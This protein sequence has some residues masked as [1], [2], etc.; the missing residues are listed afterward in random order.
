MS[1]PLLSPDRHSD[2]HRHAAH[3]ASF[4][5]VI[6]LPDGRLLCAYRVSAAHVADQGYSRL[7][8]SESADQGRTW[9]APRALAGAGHC[10][11]MALLPDDSLM[12]LDDQANQVFHSFDAGKSF[13]V[14]ANEGDTRFSLPDRPLALAKGGLGTVGHTHRGRAAQPRCGQAP[15]E[16]LF[17]RSDNGGRSWHA[18]SVMHYD[19]AL[20]LCEASVTRLIDGRLLALC[21]ENSGVGEP[22][23]ALFSADDGET[24]S[25]P[26]PTH[27]P[28]HRP[29][30]G[31][32]HDGR[33]LVTY[34]DVGPNPGTSAFLGDLDTLLAGFAP[35][36]RWLA[37]NA[38][39]LA[40]GALRLDLAPSA[41]RWRLVLRPLTDPATATG[42]L[43]VRARVAQGED[44][45]LGI[46]FGGSHFRLHRQHLLLL[47]PG[48]DEPH[49]SWP[50]A[51]GEF[52][53]LELAYRRGVTRLR[54]NGRSLAEIPAQA[55]GVATRP[56]LLGSPATAKDHGAGIIEIA[57]MEQL[58][59]EPRYGRAYRRA[60]T[61]DQGL[62]DA[63]GVKGVL[64]LSAAE[65]A[66]HGADFGYS[67]WA[68][69]PGH[70][71]VCA[72]HHVTPSTL[73]DY[74]WGQGSFV[75][76]SRF[77]SSDFTS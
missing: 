76:A 34:R 57:S 15:I 54:L 62:P 24:W 2:I 64:R 77:F 8:L 46:R 11:R 45:A 72:S 69:I 33:L 70:G 40:P 59:A 1:A 30:L 60:W 31:R 41:N 32:T 9:S 25:E 13:T 18:R 20:A 53:R 5:D 28:G 19:P 55:A 56:V 50:V 48:A 43:A 3:Y 22:M 39:A 73:P 6:R 61:P 47:E 4:P 63:P 36:A 12:L 14:S 68:E 7:L 17:L 75:R 23:Y 58:T 10:P 67:G 27:L 65:D 29:T 21:R 42:K 16:Q 44:A 49:T 38:V 35:Q 26:Q 52:C 66:A 74:D 71:F 37:P 51:A